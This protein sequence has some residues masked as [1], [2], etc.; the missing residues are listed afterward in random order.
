MDILIGTKNPYKTEV[1][2]YM[3]KDI[4]DINIHFLKD[5]DIDINVEED[6]STLLGNAKK[7]AVEISKLTKMYVL[8]SDGGVDIPSL[9]SKWDILRNQRIVGHDNLDIEKIYKLLTLMKG[10]EGEERKVEYHLAL[11]LAKDG[12]IVGSLEGITDRGYITEELVNRDVPWG[13]WMGHVWYF[14][15]FK[16]V[17]TQLNEEELKEVMKQGDTVK[18]KL[19]GIIGEIKN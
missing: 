16:K 10:L 15:K 12:E 14:P 6:E 13:K 4:P 18:Q 11:A 17:Y 2:E 1:A 5:M 9:G 3:L 19:E 7:K 8:T